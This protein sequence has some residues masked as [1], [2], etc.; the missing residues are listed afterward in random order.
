M[1]KFL[2]F[3]LL[4]AASA[5]G[6]AGNWAG[7]GGS[8]LADPLNASYYSPGS[9]SGSLGTGS[10]WF[11]D[12]MSKYLQTTS[13]TV[14]SLKA[15]LPA[16]AAGEFLD[17]QL[18]Y[19]NSSGSSKALSIISMGV[20]SCTTG[21]NCGSTKTIAA[22]TAFAARYAQIN[23]AT[24]DFTSGNTGTGPVPDPLVPATDQY[25][26][27]ATNAFPVT[28]SNGNTQSIWFDYLVPAGT[29]SGYYSG[30]I[31]VCVTATTCSAGTEETLPVTVAIWN[32]SLP[33]TASIKSEIGADGTNGC[34]AYYG[35]YGAC[36]SFPGSSGSAD[37]GV[38][39]T[40]LQEAPLLLDHRLSYGNQLVYPS[41]HS[42]NSWGTFEANYGPYL[43]GTASNTLL[44]GAKLTLLDMSASAN[45][46]T[47]AQYWVNEFQSKYSYGQL[48][49]YTCDEP[50]D[51]AGQWAPCSSP[52]ATNQ[53]AS[54][55][56]PSLVTTD[57]ACATHNYAGSTPSPLNYI[58]LMVTSVT[59]F[60][61]LNTDCGI[62][63][64][65]YT[66]SLL[67]SQYSSWLAGGTS[68]NPRTFDLYQ[69][70]S[71]Q[72]TCSNSHMPGTFAFGGHHQGYY[73]IVIDADAARN[74]MT[75]WVDW[76]MGASMHLYYDWG[77][78]WNSSSSCQDGLGNTGS[79]PWTYFVFT[80]GNGDGT[81][82]YP[83]TAAKVG[84]TT[85]I[86]IPSIRLKLWRDGEQDYEY[87]VQ[88]H[89]KGQDSFITSQFASFG[90]SNAYTFNN[91]NLTTDTTTC[92]SCL[93]SARAAFGNQL[94]ADSLANGGG[95]G[96]GFG[97]AP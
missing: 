94:H 68:S 25:T 34:I 66:P 32:F 48:F 81:L 44:A 41:V 87:M 62:G 91:G 28:V 63:S 53:M 95:Q 14:G 46:G 59:D 64:A 57:I 72:N 38:T 79:D 11:T 71:N 50:G 74:R 93:M 31:V 6:Q 97:V 90:F 36:G 24:D 85:P 65:P 56:L 78:C 2:P 9:P 92:A 20:L 89:N 58:N 17:F 75:F 51:T 67:P 76:L 16:G 13:N 18:H 23:T 26:S 84:V 86:P 10:L 15:A 49:E 3:L 8:S 5:F 22:G 21:P 29:L 1:K 82:L 83:G 54:P 80:G 39:L 45:N 33:A 12:A 27:Q 37:L 52:G 60:D 55:V 30:T 35:S 4:L 73:N 88:L 47:D 61:P 7:T 42:P 96:V 40:N 70:C 19:K 69:G 77:E 43:L